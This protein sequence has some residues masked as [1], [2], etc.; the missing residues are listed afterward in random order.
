M[1]NLDETVRLIYDLKSEN[2]DIERNLPRFIYMRD[3]GLRE[4]QKRREEEINNLYEK[5]NANKAKIKLLESL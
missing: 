5:V 2:I 1:S 4:H 3:N